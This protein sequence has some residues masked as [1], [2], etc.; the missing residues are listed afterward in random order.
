MCRAE[1]LDVAHRAPGRRG[2]VGLEH[3][4]RAEP[5]NR[6]R[7]LLGAEIHRRRKALQ[8]DERRG[9]SAGGERGVGQLGR[10]LVGQ[11]RRARNVERVPIALQS[12]VTAIRSSSPAT[13]SVASV[14]GFGST[15]KVASV[16]TASVP[17]EPASP[18]ERS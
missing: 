14:S 4:D 12:A 18:L 8:A 15:L 3:R 6:G 11:M 10:D 16:T 17:H 1:D 9:A 5:A 13:T 7:Q 2:G